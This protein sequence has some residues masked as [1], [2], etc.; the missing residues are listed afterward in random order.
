MDKKD[1]LT[2]KET[3]LAILQGTVIGLLYGLIV[4]INRVTIQYNFIVTGAI[5]LNVLLFIL[6]KSAKPEK[7]R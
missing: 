1:S 2:I 4:S 5:S 6:L 3:L 7:Q